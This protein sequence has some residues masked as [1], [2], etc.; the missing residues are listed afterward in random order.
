MPAISPYDLTLNELSRIYRQVYSSL[1]RYD[2]Y[3]GE[4]VPDMAKSWK[5]I[6]DKTIEFELR[7]DITFHS[8][9]KFSADDV[10]YTLD[11]IISPESK[12]PGKARYFWIKGAEKIGPNTVR[13]ISKDVAGIAL[14]ALAY[15][16][17][18][19]DSKVHKALADKSTYGRVSASSAG[20]Y[21]LVSM[22]PR[23]GALLERFDGY[24]GADKYR[25]APIKYIQLIPIPERQTQIAQLLTGGVDVLRNVEPDI[26]AGLASNPDLAITTVP[27]GEF[28]YLLLDAAGRSGI[29]PLKDVRVRR[30][31]A[32]AI[33]RDLIGKTLVSGGAA[34]PPMNAICF[35]T[36]AA[37]AFGAKPPAFD[38]AGARKLLAEAGY[39]TGFSAPFYVRSP[40]KQVG[41]AIA[42]QLQKVGIKTAVESLPIT[43]YTQKRGEGQLS[44]FV[45]SRP[46]TT[47]PETT[48]VFLSLFGGQRDYALIPLIDKAVAEAEKTLRSQGA[49]ENPAGRGRPQQRNGL[50]APD[51][52]A[53]DG[54]G[55][56]QERARRTQPVVGERRGD[57][58]LFLEMMAMRF[59]S[60]PRKRGAM[61]RVFEDVL[62]PR[63]TSASGGIGSLAPQGRHISQLQ[64]P[65]LQPS[66]QPVQHET[67][68]QPR[69]RL[70]SALLADP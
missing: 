31:I 38:L 52:L 5:R 62:K 68:A 67:P 44:M 19:L 16:F 59:R 39:P 12:I 43:V 4:F 56:R 28:I 27:S 46:T 45:G 49:R 25:R 37:C 13:I 65:R 11:Y 15:E 2:E 23:R 35:P 61:R 57:F 54:A 14:D 51:R 69:H 22:D 41:E 32:M 42:L 60:P 8:G 21:K 6:D 48:Q 40:I 50:R 36:T 53:A 18:I 64:S 33:D 70:Q 34:E 17:Y 55:A 24:K 26:A 63:T 3:K 7:D 58:G 47:F 30:A 9:N 66:T 10:V 1:L 29:K 20:P